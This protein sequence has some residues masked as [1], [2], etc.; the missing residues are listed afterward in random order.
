MHSTTKLSRCVCVVTVFWSKRGVV[1]K[2]SSPVIQI[3]DEN[4]KGKERE[5]RRR[6]ILGKGVLKRTKKGVFP[7]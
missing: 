4:N 3:E 7:L 1:D 5:T 2:L 6:Y